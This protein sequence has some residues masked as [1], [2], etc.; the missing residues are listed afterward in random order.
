MHIRL[1]EIAI[2]CF[3]IEIEA[4]NVSQK[5]SIDLIFCLLCKR[6]FKIFQLTKRQRAFVLLHVSIVLWGFTAILGALISLTAFEL[7]WQRVAITSAFLLFWPGMIQKLRNLPWKDVSHFGMIGVII[8]IHW[9]CFYGSIKLANA[10][11][12]LITMSTSALFTAFLEPLFTK[13]KVNKT[14]LILSMLIIPAM[15]LTTHDFD[16]SK[17]IGFAA[18]IAA[19]FLSALFAVLNKKKINTTNAEVMTFIE[20]FS[21]LLFISLTIPVIVHIYGYFSFLPSGR[22]I[23]LMLVLSVCCTILPFLLHLRALKHISAFA[24][25]LA[26]NLE[27]VYG[28]L[29]AI[30]ILRE[31]RE[32]SLSFYL[33]VLLIMSIVFL[34]PTIKKQR[35]IVRTD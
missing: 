31:N 14:D 3:K 13:S 16:E 2:E 26:I 35:Q 10:S 19:A 11:I 33:G 8:G 21:A 20:M 18:G 9:L 1:V 32:L 23:I 5:G 4:T 7:V 24:T 6:Y 27:P 25:N 12:A 15:I 17:L 22:D 34:Y 28:I 30:F 29:M